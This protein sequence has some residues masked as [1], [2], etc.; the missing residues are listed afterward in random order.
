M[1]LDYQ[2]LHEHLERTGRLKLL[3]RV[4]AE[5]KRDALRSGKVTGRRETAE[6]NPSLISGWRGIEDGVL[7]DRTGKR[8]LIDMYQRIISPKH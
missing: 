3:P 5:L 7:T 8:A 1:T 6:Q 4:L 2:K